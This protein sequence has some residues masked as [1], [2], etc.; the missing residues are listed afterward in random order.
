MS[1][2]SVK[3]YTKKIENVTILLLHKII[4]FLLRYLSILC[5]VYNI[6]YNLIQNDTSKPDENPGRKAAGLKRMP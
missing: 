3:N 6:E 2:V 4:L 5:W 1:N